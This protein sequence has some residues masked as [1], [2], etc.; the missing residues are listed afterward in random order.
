MTGLRI[1]VLVAAM[2]A[3]F[4][5]INPNDEP[6]PENDDCQQ[7]SL[8]IV[9]RIELVNADVDSPMQDYDVQEIIFGPQGGAMVR[10]RVRASG[11]DVP[12]CMAMTMVYEKCLDE[13]CTA[14]DPDTSYPNTI[15]LQ[16]YEDGA[17]RI[18]KEYFAEMRYPLV[19]GDLARVT[20][21][22]GPD[23]NPAVASVLMWLGFE[24]SLP[25]ALRDAGPS[26]ASF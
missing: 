26:D 13:L 6:L 20:I 4:A 16:T 7:A 1:M 24:G 19:E 17:E 5:S 25:S 10:L 23:A 3:S 21:S 15:A 11:N 12:A 8:P 2:A 14:V 9:D 22:V 18:T